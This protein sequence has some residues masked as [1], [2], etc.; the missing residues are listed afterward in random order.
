MKKKLLYLTFIVLF[1]VS[2]INA[3]TKYWDFQEIATWPLSAPAPVTTPA[4]PQESNYLTETVVDKLGIFPGASTVKNFG[5]INLSNGTF[6]GYTSTTR[7]QV[8]GNGGVTA[9]TY[10]PTQRYLYFTV[11]GPCTV[12]V[13]FRH[14]SSTAGSADRSVLVTDGNSLVGSA[15]APVAGSAIVT[16]NYTTV[17]GGKLYVYSDNGVNLYKVEV[18][19][20]NV[21]TPA[22]GNKNFQKELDV[23]VFAKD[24]KIFLSNIKSST[25]VEVYNVLGALV[26]STQANAD[27]SLDINGGVYIV[28]AQSAEGEKSVK[29]IVQ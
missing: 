2:A 10:K 3:Q 29:V 5:V 21:T 12:K 1:S 23:T 6:T 26:K 4:T 22:L 9:P 27:T 15:A 25:T 20:A 28:K 7:F 19:G 13:W 14:A 8:N 17:G 24:N 11:D 16:A 18:T